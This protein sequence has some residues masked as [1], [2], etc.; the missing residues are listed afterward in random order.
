MSVGGAIVSRLGVISPS[1]SVLI[2]GKQL[3]PNRACSSYGLI[4]LF[5]AAAPRFGMDKLS[6]L[7]S[8]GVCGCQGRDFT[9]GDDYKAVMATIS[10]ANYYLGGFSEDI[11]R[12]LA[13]ILC[14]GVLNYG[15]HGQVKGRC[16]LL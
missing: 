15:E 6:Q 13:E 3:R 12:R 10:Y 7:L 2:P 14:S 8:S 9:Q 11:Q 16:L 5:F 4:S 1:K